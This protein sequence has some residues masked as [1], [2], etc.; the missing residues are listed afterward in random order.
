MTI[1]TQETIVRYK[2]NGSATDL[3]VPYPVFRGEHLSLYMLPAGADALLTDE[4]TTLLSGGYTVVGADTDSPSVVM[5]EPLPSGAQLTIARVVPLVQL[6]DLQNAGD[7][8]AEV[9]ETTFDYEEMQIQQLAE[10]VGRAIKVPI[11]SDIDPDDLWRE[12]LQAAKI[13]QEFMKLILQLVDAAL[14]DSYA[15]NVRRSVLA[16]KDVPSGGILDL[17]A[18]YYPGRNILYLSVDGMV[19]TPKR[20]ENLDPGERQYEEIGD[21]PNVLSS[22]VRVFFPIEKGMTIDVW[23][24]ASNLMKEMAKIEAMANASAVSAAEAASQAGKAAN[25]AT[26]ANKSAIAADGSATAADEAL[27]AMRTLLARV[28]AS[29]PLATDGES[30][31]KLVIGPGGVAVWQ[32]NA[33]LFSAAGTRGAALAVNASFTVPSYLVGAHQL[34]VRLEG[35]GCDAGAHYTEVGSA[36]TLSTSIKWLVAVPVDYDISVT[37]RP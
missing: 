30:G 5:S 10:A 11:N 33:T 26:A 15:F 13:V 37:V 22:Q 8:D 29:Y 12:L 7:F 9:V 31:G 32:S 2:G 1:E 21:D 17:P 18:N 24:V 25:S 27:E 14:L 4:D 20:G 6:T 35:C 28:T 23:V 16:T 3:P 19:C 36:G 34:D